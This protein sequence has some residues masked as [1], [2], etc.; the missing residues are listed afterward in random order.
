MSVGY[1]CDRINS[2]TPNGTMDVAV[3]GLLRAAN[4]EYV[5]KI[6]TNPV[7]IWAQNTMRKLKGEPPRRT[8]W[9]DLPEWFKEL[10]DSKL[11]QGKGYT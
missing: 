3:K 4:A 2:S 9:E 6:V 7:V 5:W 1:C 11:T 8:P 10:P